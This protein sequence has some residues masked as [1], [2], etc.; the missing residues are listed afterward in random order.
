MTPKR[1]LELPMQYRGHIFYLKK[2][3][4]EKYCSSE[5]KKK[6]TRTGLL[7]IKENE[8]YLCTC[9]RREP[10]VISISYYKLLTHKAN[11]GVHCS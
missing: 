5:K 9:N 11:K 7:F 1:V 8:L 4:E 3:K 2:N 10:Q 6:K